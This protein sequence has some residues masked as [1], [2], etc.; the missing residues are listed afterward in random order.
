MKRQIERTWVSLTFGEHEKRGRPLSVMWGLGGILCVFLG[1]FWVGEVRGLLPIANG[2]PSEETQSFSETVDPTARSLAMEEE[3]EDPYQGLKRYTDEYVRHHQLRSLGVVKVNNR[4]GDIIV[5]NWTLDKIR[6]QVYREAYGVTQTKAEELAQSTDVDIREYG[7]QVEILA[8]YGKGLSITEKLSERQNPLARLSLVIDAPHSVGLELWT[9][10]GSVSVK[11]WNGN[12]AIRSDDG[13]VEVSKLEGEQL[14]IT[15]AACPI[16][17]SDIEANMRIVAGQRNVRGYKIRGER[18]YLQTDSGD[19]EIQNARGKQTY[20]TRTGNLKAKALEGSI[21]FDSEQG[22]I[23]IKKGNG[24]LS[25]QTRLGNVDVEMLGWNS[26]SKGFIESKKGDVDVTLPK[27][28]SGELDIQS[29]K[30]KVIS[31]FP[32]Q[33]R[34]I[35]PSV[36]VVVTQNRIRG[37]V[38]EGGE[39]LRIHSQQ[40]MI[41]VRRGQF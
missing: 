18:L 13:E 23:E 5:R 24:F 11:D 30:G 40:G 27:G 6:I 3:D 17:L 14:Q 36:P 39:Q 1:S 15:C 29:E 26:V 33:K 37:E 4:R 10:N 41:T 28:F 25:G 19:L 21:Q 31:E 12:V 32:V 34:G 16:S 8:R 35:G 20:V 22:N 9:V 2:A 38:G 7:N